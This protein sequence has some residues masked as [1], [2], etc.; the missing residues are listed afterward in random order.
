LIPKI[1]TLLSTQNNGREEE[2]EEE[3]KRRE[4]K[5]LAKGWGEEGRGKV[6]RK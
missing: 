6:G 1:N 3:E 5:G 2:K 4:R